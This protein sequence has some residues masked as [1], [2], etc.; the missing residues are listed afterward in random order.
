MKSQLLLLTILV[1]TLIIII[2]MSWLNG[3]MI[4]QL[5]AAVL[6]LLSSAQPP[7]PASSPQPLVASWAFD[8]GD[9]ATANDASGNGNN[10]MLLGGVGEGLGPSGYTGALYFTGGLNEHLRVPASQSLS[11]FDLPSTGIITL[12][13]WIR[14]SGGNYEVIA[15]T[16]NANGTSI[17]FAVNGQQFLLRIGTFIASTDPVLTPNAWQHIAVSYTKAT[18]RTTFALDGTPVTMNSP[19]PAGQSLSIT[20]EIIIGNSFNWAGGFRGGVDNMRLYNRVLDDEEIFVDRNTP[21]LDPSAPYPDLVVPSFRL[22]PLSPQ[23]GA[24]LDVSTT[25]MNRGNAGT[26]PSRTRLRIDK[27]DDGSWDVAAPLLQTNGLSPS[28]STPGIWRAVWLATAGTHRIQICT[29]NENVNRELD[30]VNNCL[31]ERFTVGPA[32]RGTPTTIRI[33]DA[34]ILRPGV[35]RFGINLGSVSGYDVSQYMKSV[36][37]PSSMGFEGLLYQ[38]IV[39][40]ETVPAPYPP[41]SPDTTCVGGGDWPEGLWDGGTYE[42]IWGSARGRSGTIIHQTARIP[43]NPPM[44][45]L[46]PVFTFAATPQPIAAED[47]II[48]RKQMIGPALPWNGTGRPPRELNGWWTSELGTDGVITPIA[49]VDPNTG[50]T[51]AVEL[52]FP[53]TLSSI[54]DDWQGKTF[55]Y[56]RGSYEVKIEAKRVTPGAELSLEVARIPGRTD[57]ARCGLPAG[58]TCPQYFNRTVPL[59]DEWRSYSFPFTAN[60]PNGLQGHFV[61][62]IRPTRG[63]IAVDNAEVRQIEQNNPT[64]FRNDVINT[65]VAMKPGSVR[66]WGGQL[67]DTLDNMLASPEAR[68]RTA[69]ASWVAPEPYAIPAPNGGNY[70]YGLYQFLAL[71]KTVQERLGTSDLEPW[72]V[73]P[74][75]TSISEM[76]DWMEYLGGDTSTRYGA[77]RAT[78]GQVAPWK[79]VF[80]RI[81]LEFGNEQWNPIFG[82][83]GILL[84]IPFGNRANEVFAAAKTS[85]YYETSRFNF[86]IGGQAEYINR[87]TEQ[88]RRSGAHDAVALAPYLSDIVDR[89]ASIEDL[90]G[91]HF[92]EAYLTSHARPSPACPPPGNQEDGWSCNYMYQN[93]DAMR[94]S[95][96]PI[97][98]AVYE[99]NL[100]TIGGDI[101]RD[102]QGLD[103]LIPTVGTGVAMP[104]HMLTML[105][106]LGIYDQEFFALAQYGF[107][108]PQ[109]TTVRLWGGTVDIG[110]EGNNRKRPQF[111][112]V[113]LIN[114]ILRGDM[115]RTSHEGNDPTWDQPAVNR[116]VINT[117]P[118]LHS[119]AFKDAKTRSLAV[120]NLHRTSALPIT[121]TGSGAPPTSASL[122]VRTLTGKRITDTNETAENV[123]V[124]LRTI[125][126]YKST[127]RKHKKQNDY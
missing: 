87:N 2:M 36:T 19:I 121:L 89:F 30:E 8:E 127:T 119:F 9:G 13:A 124:A 24:S 92:A 11:S 61:F 63:I 94:Q 57:P 58:Q 42:V 69:F 37:F 125:S 49:H 29:D 45:D 44:Q 81:H 93:Y 107:Q 38:T 46:P 99:T 16:D 40:C 50:S 90:F 79:T 73:I 111:L 3:D 15:G 12:T 31:S 39:T 96:R 6:K 51:R 68:L 27:N 117:V 85:P 112:G 17:K 83:G 86:I 109:G 34:A 21:I 84:P 76:R 1:V 74:S 18:G 10:G 47:I 101:I 70:E 25:V 114:S 106:E 55:R 126:G 91:S 64:E 80:R 115:V 53:A 103:R 23:G 113:A 82:G 71:V 4:N 97:P 52:T 41:P 78:Q 22:T 95:S 35:K 108:T 66:Y 88:H 14:P 5:V 33:D 26:D 75:T 20:S 100:H 43:G 110:G 72:I 62:R 67:S 98:L 102:Q 56:M 122:S 7:P 48:L 28:N 77:L 120:F 118:F 60:D 116:V 65:L 32:P 104:F 59:T 54:M 123:R 105:R